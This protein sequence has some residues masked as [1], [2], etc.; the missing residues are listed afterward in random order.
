MQID[1]D[2]VM[3]KL[4]SIEGVWLQLLPSSGWSAMERGSEFIEPID[5]VKAI[6]I[7]D[8][9]HVAMYWDDW[10]NY[11]AFIL[12][13][14]LADGRKPGYIN[15]IQKYLDWRLALRENPGEFVRHAPP[16]PDVQ[17]IAFAA[18]RLASARSGE[19][20]TPTSCD[21]LFC[22]CSRD[23]GL[24]EALQ[25]AGLQLKELEAAI[26]KLP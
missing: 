20:G 7:V 6:Y 15:R 23:P 5:L 2:S 9:E 26:K 14:R 4:V 16:S 18:Q 25:Q 19:V 21:L 17:E 12:E 11:E 1:M 10:R 8:L 24:S 3:V 13:I 22:A